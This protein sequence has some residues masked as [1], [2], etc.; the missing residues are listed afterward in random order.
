[1]A[2]YGMV[3][4]VNRCIGCYNC[5]LACRDEHAGNDH[6]PIA[7]AQPA[8]GHRWIDV[9]EQERGSFP[10]VKVS[11][12][13]VPCLHCAQAS[14]ISAATDGA[15]YRRDDGIVL[16]DA[17]K[18]VGRRD[19]VSSC[20]HRVIFWNEAEN[21]PQKCTLCAHLLD[22]GWKEPRCVEAC[23]TQALAFGDPSDP[24][25]EVAKL[26]TAHAIE[27]LHPEYD[28]RPSVGYLGLPKRFVAGEVVLADMADLAAEGVGIALQ[29]GSQVLTTATDNY[30]D[31]EFDGLE[32]D[33]EYLLRITHPGY[34]RQELSIRTRTDLNVG[35]IVLEPDVGA[36]DARAGSRASA[37]ARGK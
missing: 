26:R 23:P 9:R 35:S 25:S 15:V 20:P 14:C 37:E 3:I 21:V 34:R 27:D 22:A 10:K 13:P 31:F 1:M 6:R 36:P 11:H 16:I 7:L 4:D 30:G 12:V 29:R 2:R 8:A 18:A 5:F 32:A 28:L 17:D 19:I 33:T 24:D